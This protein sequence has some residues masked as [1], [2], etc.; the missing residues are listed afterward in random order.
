MKAKIINKYSI[1]VVDYDATGYMEYQSSPEPI[2]DDTQ[3]AT[4]YYEEIDGIIYQRWEAPM[5]DRHKVAQ[6]IEQLKSELIGQDYKNYK[7]LQGQL[8]ESE[9]QEFK[10]WAQQIRNQINQLELL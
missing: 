6:K 10:Q 3:G 2:V 9:W 1:D 4:P 8:S 5:L 7:Y